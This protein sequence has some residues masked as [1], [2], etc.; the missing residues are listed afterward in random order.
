M[1]YDHSIHYT[2]HTLR[3]YL[4]MSGKAML[5]RI[6]DILRMEVD[7]SGK[8]F[9]DVGCSTAYITA[10]IVDEFK[11]DIAVGMDINQ[12]NL[13]LAKQR[14]PHI[15][16]QVINLN[17]D[18]KPETQ[19]DV[20]ICTE[21]LEHVGEL[22]TAIDNLMKLKKSN[23]FLLILV[24]DEIGW[25]G[26]LRVLWRVIRYGYNALNCFQEVPKQKFLFFKYMWSL[27]TGERVSK[28]RNERSHWCTHFGFDYRD[29]DDYL[30]V[31]NV[32]FCAYNKFG[33]RYYIVRET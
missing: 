3:Q 16:F 9:A 27:L 1:V 31:K 13:E 33:N 17:E 7:F 29:I 30:Q 11:P 23:G 2:R 19:Y 24:P 4:P 18:N 21:T 6:L 12:P 20:L 10:V 28:Y 26:F 32:D 5:N 8:S 14:Y 15:Q 22:T 25:L